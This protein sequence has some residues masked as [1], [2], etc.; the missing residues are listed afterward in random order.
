MRMSRISSA[1]LGLLAS[2]A[3]AGCASRPINER[4]AK[5]DP[6]SGY[7][8]PLQMQKLKNNDPRTLFLLA[9]SGGGTRAAAFSYGVL[10]ELR[11]TE[12]ALVRASWRQ[13]VRRVR[14]A[15]PEARCGGNPARADDEPLQLAAPDRR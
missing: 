8:V 10:E 6:S 2:I 4:I 5:T 3:L 1:I 15:L 9:F 12:A 7:R 13:A 14:D 11:R